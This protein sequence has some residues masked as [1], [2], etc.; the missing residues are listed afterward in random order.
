MAAM[1]TTENKTTMRPY[2]FVFICL[3]LPCTTATM[4]A[5]REEAHR[6]VLAGGY[7]PVKDLKSDRLR[8]V[9]DFCMS[10]LVSG[11]KDDRAASPPYS[12]LSSVST[13]LTGQVV[14]AEQQVVAG[15]N[16]RMVVL[17]RS[18]SDGDAGADASGSEQGDAA[19][20][21]EP[22]GAFRVTV[23]DRFGDMSV[24]KWDEEVSVDDAM[25]MLV[26]SAEQDVVY[27]E[28]P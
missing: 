9:V 6:T 25:K 10:A 19:A 13:P 7:A 15:M 20:A 5:N 22:V 18:D 23:Y 12:F 14:E 3:L 1:R 2:L 11:E 16:Y 4:M 24:T 17:V 26:E 8:K 27:E 21:S 28:N